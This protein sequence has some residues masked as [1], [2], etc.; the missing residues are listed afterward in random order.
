MENKDKPVYPVENLTEY[1]KPD[2][3]YEVEINV[4]ANGLTKLEWYIGMATQGVSS[5]HTLSEEQIAI[6][7]INIAKEISDRVEFMK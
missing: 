2:N 5:D 3:G 4:E 6:R 1:V 7:A